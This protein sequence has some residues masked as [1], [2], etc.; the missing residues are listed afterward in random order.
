M[1]FF[2][3]NINS[4]E[5]LKYLVIKISFTFKLLIFNFNTIHSNKP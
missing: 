4:T 5:S 1:E 3:Y 2:I